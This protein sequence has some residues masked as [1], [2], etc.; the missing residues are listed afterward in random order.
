M[1]FKIVR[2]TAIHNEPKQTI[3]ASDE[4]G[5]LRGGLGRIMNLFELGSVQINEKLYELI[6]YFY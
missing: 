3:S 6:F 1:H 2:L 4:F 5:L